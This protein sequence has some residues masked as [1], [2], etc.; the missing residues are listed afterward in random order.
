[1]L[2]NVQMHQLLMS[3]LVVAALNPRPASPLPQ[4]HGLGVDL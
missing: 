1:M 3:R 2:Q 4:V